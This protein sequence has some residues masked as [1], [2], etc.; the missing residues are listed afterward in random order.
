MPLEEGAEQT[1]EN[2]RIDGRKVLANHRLSQPYISRRLTKIIKE[3][4]LDSFAAELPVSRPTGER[5]QLIVDRWLLNSGAASRILG[6]KRNLS[7]L[8]A[9]VIAAAE[10]IEFPT[11]LWVALHAHQSAFHF[12]S[13]L[14]GGLY[15]GGIE[16]WQLLS[17]HFI[18]RS[19]E[20]E[21]AMLARDEKLRIAVSAQ[22]SAKVSSYLSKN[23]TH[24]WEELAETLNTYKLPWAA[25][26]ALVKH[27]WFP[28][29]T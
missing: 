22:I 4:V 17:L 25:L 16:L 13:T 20:W 6:R 7:F 3:A 27:D 21:V 26:E 11:G 15:P 24:T 1:L 29:T 10:H 9:C 18:S 12:V 2:W 28:T 8:N 19:P 14:F 23:S 5:Q